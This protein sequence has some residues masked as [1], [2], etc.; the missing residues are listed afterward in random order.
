MKYKITMVKTVPCE[1]N[2]SGVTTAF[3]DFDLTVENLTEARK[4][5]KQRNKSWT[6]RQIRR[7][8]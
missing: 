1:R 4:I 6:L 3:K 8:K 5:A 7:S 2:Q